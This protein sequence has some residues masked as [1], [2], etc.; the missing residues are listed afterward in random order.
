MKKKILITGATGY[1][2]RR[3]KNLLI[4]RSDLTIRLMVRNRN[5]LSPSIQK[6]GLCGEVEIVEGE[7][8]DVESISRA[9]ENIDVAFYLIHSMGN[10]DNDFAARDRKSAE[11]F[12]DASI[13]AGVKRIVYLGGLGAKESASQHLLSRIETGE[14]L[15]AHPEKIETIWLRAA[16]IIGSGSASFE[17]VR[18]LVQKLPVMITPR[19]VNTITQP[20]AVDDVLAYLE[21]SI[22]VE[23]P[24]DLV[25]DIGTAPINF[26]EMM[27]K[28]ANV[29]G[30]KRSLIPVP[31][32]TPKLSSYW[33]I[34]F[35]PISFKMAAALIEGL[36]SETILLNDNA[37]RYFPQIVP[38][39]FEEA[40][41]RAIDEMEHRQVISR[42]CDS[43]QEKS[44]D[45]KEFDSP[46][47]VGESVGAVLRDVREFPINMVSSDQ[48]FES[49]CSLGGDS[50]WFAYNFLWELRGIIDKISGGVGLNR[51]RRATTAL[52]VGDAVDFWKVADIRPCRRL[53]LLAQM[54]V[55]GKAWLEFDIQKDRNILVQTAHFH[56]RGLL[57]RIYWFSVMPL[58]HFIF[59][60]LGEKIIEHAVKKERFE[61]A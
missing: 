8:F 32:L 17:I 45:I 38:M 37:L 9:L 31:L 60:L 50:G 59:K 5:K 26:R 34:L 10:S 55:P 28:T 33:L 58:H 53:L 2:G 19:W 30:L 24:G 61:R 20:I 27:R 42:W 49:I 40:V 25:V 47:V 54:K 21:A 48:L 1:V 7:T 22:S 43:S 14:I 52:R 16:I 46:S 57:G 36:K 35:T 44:C 11:N 13:A 6:K 15:S 39:P 56:P 51:G 18:H 4:D 3:L 29:M 12:R 23:T 41:K